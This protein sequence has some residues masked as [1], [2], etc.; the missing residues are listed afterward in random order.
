[1]MQW[2]SISQ[3]GVYGLWKVLCGKMAQEVPEMYQSQRGQEGYLQR[4]RL[5]TKNDTS[6]RSNRGTNLEVEE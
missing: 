2:R 5:T 6:S 4:A 1:M 3:E